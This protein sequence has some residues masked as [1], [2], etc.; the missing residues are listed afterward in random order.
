MKN[1]IPKPTVT[2]GAR[3]PPEIAARLEKAT[4]RSQDPWAP[5][6]SQII[7]RGIELALQEREAKRG[8]SPPKRK[9]PQKGPE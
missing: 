8:E 7:S 3:I 5:T 6:I 1:K 2:V 9:Q 4:D